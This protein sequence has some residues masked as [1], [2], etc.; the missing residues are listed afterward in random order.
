MSFSFP[1]FFHVCLCAK[2]EVCIKKL[3]VCSKGVLVCFPASRLKTSMIA[4]IP[5]ARRLQWNSKLEGKLPSNRG[6][7]SAYSTRMRNVSWPQFDRL[8]QVRNIKEKN[9][10]LH[11]SGFF[12]FEKG[13]QCIWREKAVWV[14]TKAYFASLSFLMQSRLLHWNCFLLSASFFINT[15]VCEYVCV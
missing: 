12:V 11:L 13:N 9:A 8:S 1:S 7:R 4:V 6:L 14:P 10:P 2:V 15:S 3:L 5:P